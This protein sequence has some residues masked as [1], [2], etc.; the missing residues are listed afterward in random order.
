MSNNEWLSRCGIGARYWGSTRERL[1]ES[2]LIPGYLDNLE[3][4]VR[5]GRGLLLLG[6]VG[7]GK[8]AA[9]ALIAREA[10]GKIHGW[11]PVWYCTTS[12]LMSHLL[13]STEMIRRQDTESGRGELYEVDPKDATLLLLDEFGA[14]YESEYAMAAFEDY[15]GW[16]YDQKLATC[17]AANLTPD[18]I[19]A[20]PHYARMADRWRETCRVVLIEGASMRCAG[21]SE[22]SA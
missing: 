14:A 22:G 21:S 9:L 12:R 19:R 17:V 15:L 3:A 18:Q 13:R 11:V 16:R 1:R 5:N 2:E 8:T 20:K 7:V 4:E 10:E 6:P